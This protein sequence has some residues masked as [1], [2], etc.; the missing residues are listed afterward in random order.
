[1]SVVHFVSSKVK[2]NQ[3]LTGKLV[4]LTKKL[5]F[6]FIAKNELVAIKLHIGERGC[7]SFIKPILVWKVIEEV[8]KAGGKPFLTDTNALY[9]GSRQNAVDHLNLAEEHG[10]TRLGAPFIIADGL[11]STDYVEVE[12]NLK[13][14]GTIKYAST[15]HY[16]DALICLSHFKGHM[17]T[18]FGGSIKNVGMGISCRSFKQV[19]HS[20][21]KPRF[22]DPSLCT[23][24]GKCLAICPAE[25]AI[26]IIN[27]KA[28]FIH[29]KC[30]GCADCITI[31]PENA[32]KI[33]WN[34]VPERVAEK[35]A[36]AAYG[37]LNHKKGKAAFFNFLLDITPDCDCFPWSDNPIVPDIGIVV[38]FDPVAIDQASADLVNQQ[39]G[40][41]NSA[42]DGA[43]EPGEDK[44]SCL[45]P[46]R[47]WE[48]WLDY[49]QQIGLGEREYELHNIESGEVFSFYK[50]R[51]AG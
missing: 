7:T 11:R 30:L 2:D 46:E 15:I 47:N 33:L 21:V 50:K 32:L 18:S 5:G 17:L 43:F 45:R 24:C 29:E 35:I 14:F 37:I 34:E 20:E 36:E 12:A 13:H 26:K 28:H 51:E 1:M 48:A 27:K 10:F 19:L 38:S 39:R 6:D 44:L 41:Q 8:K 31:C 42:L 3:G 40:L 49:A 23:G 25:E 4:T 16:A 9:R 22:R